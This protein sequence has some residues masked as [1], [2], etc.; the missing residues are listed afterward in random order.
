MHTDI[1][2]LGR[3]P[4]IGSMNQTWSE[5]KPGKPDA[6]KFDIA[7]ASTCKQASNCGESAT[8][9]GHRLAT[10]QVHT[11]ARLLDAE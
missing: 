11:L 9:L 7:G 10:R 5:F 2:P 1:T 4:P 6:T 3:E 8:W